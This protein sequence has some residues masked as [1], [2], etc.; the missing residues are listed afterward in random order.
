MQKYQ[1]RLQESIRESE[2]IFDSINLLYYK[3][4]KI[5]LTRGR[6]YINSPKWLKDKKATINWKNKDD[7]CFKHTVA[8][9]L[10]YEQIKSHPERISKI[11]S[12]IDQYNWKGV[13]FPSHKKD[14]KRFELNNKSIALNILFMSY[15]A[16]EIRLAY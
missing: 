16:K 2:F 6:S 9:T 15:N 5:S 4:Q 14:W 10:N 12:F 11:K 8:V 7:K 13:D 1:E 3:L